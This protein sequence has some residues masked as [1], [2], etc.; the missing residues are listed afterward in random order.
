MGTLSR[1]SRRKRL[2][3]TFCIATTAP[4][5]VRDV[6]C[7]ESERASTTR[8]M[9]VGR[10]VH[11]L[12]HEATHNATVKTEQMDHGLQPVARRRPRR[13]ARGHARRCPFSIGAAVVTLLPCMG[14]EAAGALGGAFN[15]DLCRILATAK[16]VGTLDSPTDAAL[17]EAGPPDSREKGPL[18]AVGA[19]SA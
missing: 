17:E 3:A 11:V 6:Q 7:H 12:T 13:R 9:P 10:K 16:R 5:I 1:G 2:A 4:A 18:P 8:E 14:T 19:R 15:Q